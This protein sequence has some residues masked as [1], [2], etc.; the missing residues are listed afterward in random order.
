MNCRVLRQGP[1]TETLRGELDAAGVDCRAWL[2]KRASILKDESHS[3][4]GLAT[5]DQRDCCLKL[6]IN[7]SRWP[8]PLLGHI[9]A[10]AVRGFDTAQQ[11]IGEGAPVPEP[12]GC[13]RVP[14]GSL[15]VT[16][17]VPGADLATLW[18]GDPGH[19]L[20]WFSI[21][22]RSAQA[23]AALHRAG[24]AH[25]DCKWTNVILHDYHCT[26]VDFENAVPAARASRRQAADIA[27]FT[28]SA[29]EAQLPF[30]YYEAFLETYC[31]A[32]GRGWME[33]TSE[34]IPLLVHLRRR[35]TGK[36]CQRAH[37]L[38]GN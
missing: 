2:R 25:G 26:L 35:Y 11:L 32:T 6:F 9:A 20:D 24:Y 29:E 23:I 14:E 31:D 22:Q 15:L 16:A 30:E 18:L 38:L 36:S 28:L 7:R 13:L 33:I 17:A 34:V 12:L 10:R 1:L 21:M 5:I 3:L 8:G 27:R 37:P 4:V 19:A